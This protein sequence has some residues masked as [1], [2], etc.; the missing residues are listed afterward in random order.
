VPTGAR[1]MVDDLAG[2]DTGSS[3]SPRVRRR[4]R[5]SRALSRSA[6]RRE[7]IRRGSSPRS[8]TWVCVPSWSPATRR[9]RPRRSPARSASTAVPALRKYSPA[10]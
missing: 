4:C 3:R 8:A 1:R 7:R 9:L 2:R 6:I 10:S 5:D